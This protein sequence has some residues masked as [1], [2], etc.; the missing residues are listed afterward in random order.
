MTGGGSLRDVAHRAVFRGRVV[1]G[2]DDHGGGQGE[3][4]QGG[5]IQVQRSH[6]VAVDHH[7]FTHHAHGDGVESNRSQA[8]GDDQ[9]TVQGVHDLA[10]VTCLDE[11]GA[12]D[13]GDDGEAAQ[14]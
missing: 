11:E 5:K 14:H 1:L 8:A 13:G 12:D 10:A 6:Q 2:D 9:A 3:A 7:A 4:D